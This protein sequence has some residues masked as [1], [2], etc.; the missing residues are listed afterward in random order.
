MPRIIADPIF[1]P[2]H[3]FN[4]VG[5]AFKNIFKINHTKSKAIRAFFYLQ[6]DINM[7]FGKLYFDN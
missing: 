7:Y 2:K 4:T 1:I 6:S 5:G 3:I